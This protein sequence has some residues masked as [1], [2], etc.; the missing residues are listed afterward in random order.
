M[1][2]PA[3]RGFNPTLVRLRPYFAVAQVTGPPGF[4]PTLV[5]LR[6]VFPFQPQLPALSFQSH[7]GSIEAEPV[8][9]L[10]ACRHAFQSH[11]GSIEARERKVAGWASTQVSIPRWFD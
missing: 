10:S 5:R 9:A 11:A 1:D 8:A 6:Q 4:N 7:A 3:L 2:R